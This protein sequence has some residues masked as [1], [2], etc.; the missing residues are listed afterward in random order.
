MDVIIAA[1]YAPVVIHVGLHALPTTN[2]M[3]YL[4]RYN[5]EGDVTAEEH[6]V[7]F[8]SFVDNFNI[9]YADMWMTFFVQSLYGKVWKWFRGLTPSPIV[10]IEVL[11]ETFINKW[12]D[13]RYYLYY[14]TDFGALKRN[15]GESILYFTKIFNKMYGRILDEIKPTEASANITYANAFDADFSLL[16]RER[17]SNSLFSMQESSIE[18]ESN[19]LASGRLKTRFDK[20]KKK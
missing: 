1:R 8:Y 17:R 13:K 9:D 3:K 4:P 16:L 14:I 11:D 20:E 15:N 18:V 5:G 12:E 19:I 2:Y 10:D 6:L 7:S